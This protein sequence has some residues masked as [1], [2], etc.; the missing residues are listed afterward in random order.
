MGIASD[1]TGLLIEVHKAEITYR[2]YPGAALLS[3]L[4]TC[5]TICLSVEAMPDDALRFGLIRIQIV[6]GQQVR[7]WQTDHAA[8]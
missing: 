8:E 2:R 1:Y 6:S 4:S 3:A 5:T 7:L